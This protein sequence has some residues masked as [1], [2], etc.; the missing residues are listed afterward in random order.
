MSD[1][2][3]LMAK[4]FTEYLQER[5]GVEVAITVSGSLSGETYLDELDRAV[6]AG[7]E[8]NYDVLAFPENVWTAVSTRE[9]A[10]SVVTDETFSASELRPKR[11]AGRPEA[12]AVFQL[13]S[14]TRRQPLRG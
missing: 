3:S 10:T 11:D 5:Y 6:E 14:A 12:A 7:T 4:Q 2:E 8:P 9:Q 13:Q 1:A